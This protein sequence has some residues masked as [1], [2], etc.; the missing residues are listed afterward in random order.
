MAKSRRRLTVAIALCSF[1]V[2]AMVCAYAGKKNQVHA[3]VN[4][5]LGR[6]YSVLDETFEERHARWVLFKDGSVFDG[7]PDGP[8]SQFNAAASRMKKPDSWGK[9]RIDGSRLEIVWDRAKKKGDRK[10][11]VYT[12]WF[13]LVMPKA[14]ATLAG[15]YQR[16]GHVSPKT[17]HDTTFSATGWQT[18]VFEKSGRFTHARG[19]GSSLSGDSG[20]LS[21][22]GSDQQGGTYRID[23]PE[24]VMK[25]QDGRVVRASLFYS[26]TDEK[27]IFIDGSQLMR[28]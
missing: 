12:D 11:N 17:S 25:Y 20:S 13:P 15:A 19:G 7:V 21:S 9:W 8:F 16:A 1:L 28:R 27:I 4:V 18:I 2:V 23:G 3:V 26:S 6:S 10:P 24:L 22:H 14:G 5:S